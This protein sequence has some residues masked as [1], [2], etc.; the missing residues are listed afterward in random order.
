MKVVYTTAA[1]V[2]LVEIAAWI[3]QDSPSHAESFAARLRQACEALAHLPRRFQLV[4]GHEASG[5][6]RRPYG[7]CLI[8]Y[9][10]KNDT[11][12]ILHVLHGARDYEKI[13]FPESD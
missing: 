4:P 2:D 3:A 12:E 10:I 9:W 6:R 1:Q 13:L 7:N 11:V 8:F 5:I